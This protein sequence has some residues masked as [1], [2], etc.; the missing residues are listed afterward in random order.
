MTPAPWLGLTEAEGRKAV[1]AALFQVLFVGTVALL[2][3]VAAALVVGRA[4][5]AILPWLY[6]ASALCTAAAAGLVPQ[7]TRAPG[8][9]LWLWGTAILALAGAATQGGQLPVLGLYLAADAFATLNQ[10][11]FWARAGE[12]FDLRAS[13]R[14]FAAFAAASMVGSVIGGGLAQ[15]LA[16]N[17]GPLWLAGL[18]GTMAMGCAPLGAWMDRSGPRQSRGSGAFG[19]PLSVL[20]G[21]RLAGRVALFVGLSSVLTVG[22]D[23]L[24]RARAGEVM[25]ERALATLFG[26]IN[27]WMGIVAAIFQIVLARQLLEKLGLFY[28]LGLVPTLCAVLALASLG[29]H[30]LGP[31]IALKV[32]EAAGSLSLTPLA[33]QLLY[34]PMAP[35]RR[36]AARAAIDGLVKKG[37]LGLGGL[38]LILLGARLTHWLPLVALGAAMALVAV[39]T[40]LQRVYVAELG[41]R[42]ARAHWDA[43][44]ALDAKGRSVL[45]QGLKSP[46]AAVALTSLT[47]LSEAPAELTDDDLR[48]LLVHASEKLVV[49][50]LKIVR[51]D[52]RTALLP[53]VRQILA[54]TRRRARGQAV[55]T[56]AKLAPDAIV[57][58]VE[59]LLLHEDAGTRG[60]AIAA[61]WLH[62]PSHAAAREALDG[63][64]RE[65]ASVVER[66]ELAVALGHV[67]P[68]SA[69]APIVRL[70]EDPD[71]GV[72]GLAY[73]AIARL[74]LTLFVPRL[75]EK[76]GVR[77]DRASARTALARLGE[78]AR[79]A[80][81]R[82]LNDRALPLAVRL[83]V[84]R[85]LREM[86]TSTAA[87]ALLHS[88]I[89]DD[90]VLQHRIGTALASMRRN[91]PR[92]ALDVQW[93]KDAIGRRLDAYAR[94]APVLADL[95]TTLPSSSL[96]IRAVAA[97]L[98][99]GLEVAF[100]LVALLAPHDQV[101]DAHHRL[102]RGG[103]AERAFAAE[104]LENVFPDARLR[105]RLAR[106][107]DGYHRH[108]P[109]GV[110]SRF[111]ERVRDLTTSN[112]RVLRT[113][114]VAV[115]RRQNLFEIPGGDDTMSDQVVE[116]MFLLEGVELFES[117]GVDEIAALAAIAREERVPAGKAVFR[118]GDPGDRFFVI[119]SGEVRIEREGKVF[120]RLG[121]RDSFGEV[122]L[123]DGAPRPADVI[124]ETELHLLAIDR[125]EFL[126]LVSD[127]PELLQGVLAQLAHH[128]RLMLE[129]P[130]G[131][132]VSLKR[133]AT[134]ERGAA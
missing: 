78:P 44:I 2:K 48:P 128:L 130:G 97:R 119:V 90:A 104:L 31:V 99:Q 13:R 113:V 11:R 24:F 28:F 109:P 129:G 92:L 71:R 25:D 29:M 45:H 59:P 26:A 87:N 60:A 8:R 127:R 79:E 91:D 52:H 61:L 41:Q 82:A 5:A 16:R 100:R 10:V 132:Q 95:R 126:D 120:F 107:V 50:A 18:A 106:T 14:L 108:A 117:S 47:L 23:F 111:A 12:L 86:G 63:L 77:S 69:Y 81:E 125:Q 21:D 30:G 7:Q 22:V 116:T 20:R 110:A 27:V 35:E 83:E 93:V 43:E 9:E 40:R 57:A 133:P 123:L 122:S 85:A 56:L 102:Q 94:N 134:G 96:L 101:M 34:G 64:R 89:D 62:P 46:S 73:R 121:A 53:E 1:P 88:N 36:A 118:R 33:V 80:L 131:A 4:G 114:A 103:T 67:D 65:D 70:I 19:L 84:P 54:G 105:R 17:V 124:A 37:G 74:G 42:L 49:R 15:S 98:D 66:R 58:A 112:D 39:L 55:R 72:R 3:S 76:L 6:V 115:A 38:L 75:I 68:P 51:R 32:V